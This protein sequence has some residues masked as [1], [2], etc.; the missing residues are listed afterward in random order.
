M[1]FSVKPKKDA[2]A[3]AA[4]AALAAANAQASG[5]GTTSNNLLTTKALAAAPF[6]NSKVGLKDATGKILPANITV[7]A[8]EKAMQDTRNNGPVVDAIK[9]QLAQQAPALLKNAGVTS[10]SPTGSVT[11]KEL[12][13][14][15]GLIQLGYSNEATGTPVDL[16]GILTNYASGKY[17]AGS[18]DITSTINSKSL[19][20]PNIQ[21]SKATINSIF[22]DMLGRTATDAEI[23]KYTNQYLTYASQNPTSQTSG[24]YNYGYIGTPSGTSRLMRQSTNET[25][26]QNNLNEKDFITN[27]VLGSTDY[28]SFAAANTAYGFLQNLAKQN[29]G[30]E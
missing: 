5:T 9:T 25:S 4:M 17:N 1:A 2:T 22:S 26:V 13:A 6:D 29:T 19:D 30:T 15:N 10:L 20:Q 27:Q 23:S 28:N 12:N 21:A 7:S 3:D 16:N 24:T 11:P 18:Q 8:A 14:I